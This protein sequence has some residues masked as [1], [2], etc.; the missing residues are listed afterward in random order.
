MSALLIIL[1][2]EDM[3]TKRE[4][5]ID[6]KFKYFSLMAIPN[7]KFKFCKD[8]ITYVHTILSNLDCTV[9]TLKS[10]TVRDATLDWGVSFV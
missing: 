4:K 5:N 10:V 9:G 1:A 2:T 7:L 3:K 6:Q 8:S